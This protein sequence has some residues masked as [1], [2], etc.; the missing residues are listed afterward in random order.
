MIMMEPTEV[1][2]KNNFFKFHKI[3][4]KL[5]CGTPIGAMFAPR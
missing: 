2:L 3:F 5:L 1:A 4:F